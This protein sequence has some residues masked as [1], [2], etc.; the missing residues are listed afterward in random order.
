[1]GIEKT[2]ERLLALR[3]MRN[4][5]API[6][7]L[8]DEILSIIFLYYGTIVESTATG[9]WTKLMVVCRRWHKVCLTHAKLWSYIVPDPGPVPRIRPRK[10]VE[11]G[12]L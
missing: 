12:A 4:T 6:S 1:E 9:R 8:P 3:A 5:I 10:A 7:M 11:P 2:I